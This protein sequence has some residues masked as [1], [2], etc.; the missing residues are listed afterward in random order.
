MEFH[1]KKYSILSHLQ[2][3]FYPEIC[4]YCRK[5]VRLGDFACEKCAEAFPTEPYIRRAVGG[6]LSVSA[7][8]YKDNYAA[9]ILSFK[10]HNMTQ[11]KT[12]LAIPVAKA[13]WQEFAHIDFDFVT[14]VPLHKRNLSERGYN[15]SELIAK[16]MAQMLSIPYTNALK[17]TRFNQPQHSMKGVS[18][19]ASNVKGVYKA[20]DP[21]LIQGKTILLIDDI[22]TTGNTLGECAN[23]LIKH[24]A[25]EVYCATFATVVSKTT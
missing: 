14:C 15:Q 23:I 19:R 7:A 8:P 20:T 11:H 24:G 18:K 21:I 9:A 2:N 16:E 13:V 12:Q 3:I 4:P 5:V 1:Q 22:I 25:K 6:Y 10:F 17:K